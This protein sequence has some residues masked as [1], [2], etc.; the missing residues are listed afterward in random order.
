M[1]P[2]PTIRFP[3]ELPISARA[4]DIAAA[5]E[6]RQVVIVAG[7][8]GSGKTT[9]LPKIALAMGRGERGVIG[10]TQPRR[11]AATSVAARVASELGTPIGVDVGYQI[12]FED[13]SS[14]STRV[15]FMTD[16]I[17]LAE[18]QGDPTLRRYDTLIIDEAH[19]RSLTID[20][21]LGWL[22]QLLPRRPDLKVIVSS[23]T[24]ETERFSAF[25]GGAPIIEVEGRTYPV[26]VLYEPP[27]DDDELPVAV[28]NAVAEV[29]GL[30][31]HGDVLAFL[32]GEREIRE[33]EQELNSRGL[34]NTVIMPLY[35]RLSAGE[36]ASVFT[37]G[38]RRR[39]VLAT[40]VAETSV[41][42]PGIVYVVD[43]GVARVSRY[44]SRSGITRLQ[45]EAISQAS[46]D[47]RKGRCGRVRPGICVRLY[48]EDS[49]AARPAFTDPEIT[50]SGLAGVIL[51]MKSLGLGEIEAF[52]FLDPPSSRAIAEGYKVLEELGAIDDRKELTAL[53]GRLARF[54]VDPRIGRMIL[55]GADM[56]CLREVLIITA[57]LSTQDPRE[58]PREL[59]TKADELH[60]RFRDEHSDFVAL[61]RMWEFVKEA[62]RKGTSNL[63]RTCRDNFLSFLR[64]REWG[65]VH[66]QLEDIASELRLGQ[67]GT[68]SGGQGGDYHRAIL[69]GILS[70]IGE[71]D[72]E[73]RNYIGG[74]QT[75]FQLHPS[76]ALAKKPPAWV[77]AFELVDTSQLFARMAARID[78]LWLLDVADHLVKRSYS[79]PHWSERAG[80][81]SVK[82]TC[83]LFGLTIARDRSVDYAAIN[84][85]GARRLF[86]DYALIRGEYESRGG[87]QAKNVAV[88]AE[89]SKIR[90]RARRSDLLAD[91]GA[92]FAFFEARI[93]ADVVNGKTFEDWRDV[94]E[95]RDPALLCFSLEHIFADDT[96]LHPADYPDTL[97]L[98]GAKLPVSYRF[99]PACDDD[100]ITLTIP[101]VM[102]PQ[103]DAG[104]LDW[105]IPGWHREKLEALLQELPKTTRR[106][107][108]PLPAL[109]TR[110]AAALTP[111]E[112]A[113]LPALSECLRRLTSVDVP[114]AAWRTDLIPP[115]LRATVALTD[116]KGEVVAQGRKVDELFKKYGAKARDVWQSVAPPKAFE[117]KGLTTWDFDELPPFIVRRVGNSDVRSYPALVDRGNAV[118]L[119]LMQSA[120][121]AD[122]ATRLGLR[123][124]A[125]LAA[126]AA[127]TSVTLR[128]PLSLTRTDGT[129]A[130]RSDDDTFRTVLLHALVDVAF[131]LGAEHPL[132]RTRADYERA[133]KAGGPRLHVACDQY[134]AAIESVRPDL[135]KTLTA[136]H[137]ASRHLAAKAA[138]TD[139]HAQLDQLLPPDLMAHALPA[140]LAHVPRYLRAI[141]AR[142]DRAIANPK[143]DA[144]KLAPL[145]PVWTRLV[146]KRKT[147][148]DP[149]E[150]FEVLLMFEELRVATFAPELKPAYPV[151]LQKVA[152][153]V[154]ALA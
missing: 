79:A 89:A 98:H 9:Q 20:F 54:P 21:L 78:P 133:I 3:P 94:A 30:D 44:D 1:N 111:F 142:L 91:D 132:P 110:L 32:P 119:E 106:E 125:M 55:A 117:R 70:R 40:N 22:K 64:V 123:R 72:P 18:I 146:Q 68:R 116:P 102:V 47:Q 129:I 127:I 4:A 149:G 152:A 5:I 95:K 135:Q 108:G 27:P 147:A 103:L 25:F 6:S 80:R 35:A 66:R 14:S 92:L 24:I 97:T 38:P 148:K 12:R 100:G 17:L 126:R 26:D 101:L 82:E 143:K 96:D 104:E 105:T 109:A 42:I 15:K 10:V 43:A 88:Q 83:T 151:S 67:A 71:W 93:P 87:F 34:R 145:L 136:I 48:D 154:E 41:T 76:S 141:T 99:D 75:R 56:G 121:A 62:E 33:T 153:A 74:K 2:H 11:I 31:P 16:G 13:R 134:T 28:A 115:F 130:R 29:I 60:R 37:T 131:N 81:A 124:L 150:A 73:K 139:T 137:N 113:M 90:A 39:V 140:D 122:A 50:R 138:I 57:G 63:R 46:A 118:D 114:P 77:M 112:G 59:Q 84:P 144:D 45:V 7:A 58:R 120:P 23:A 61:L 51:R 49:F 107:L 128:L 36:Q 8:T 85:K 52:P 19:E 53:G 69:T 65:E 86:I